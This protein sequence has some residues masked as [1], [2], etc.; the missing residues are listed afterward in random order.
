ME[1][2]E[3]KKINDLHAELASVKSD[4]ARLRSDFLELAS[5]LFERGKEEFDIKKESVIKGGKEACQHVEKTLT[6]NPVRT[7]LCAFGLGFLLSA[8]G[9]S[10]CSHHHKDH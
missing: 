5:S 6:E 3:S 8:L 9:R 7:L 2:Q 1:N 4:V 10:K